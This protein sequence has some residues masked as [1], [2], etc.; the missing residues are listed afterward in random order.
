MLHKL[1]TNLG[2]LWKEKSIQ[3]KKRLYKVLIWNVL[4]YALW[5]EEKQHML[6]EALKM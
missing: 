6:V 1:L 4:A 3:L 5:K 2:E